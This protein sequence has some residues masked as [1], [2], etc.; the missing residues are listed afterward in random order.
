MGLGK[1][2]GIGALS[3]GGIAALS[4]LGGWFFWV[5][6]PSPEDQCAHVSELLKKE[7][8]GLKLGDGFMKDCPSKMQKGQMEGLVPYAE[9]SKCVMN[10]QSLDEATQCGKKTARN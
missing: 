10:S 1:V 8:G 5:R 4:L 9:R 7:S 2:M 6:A 3:L